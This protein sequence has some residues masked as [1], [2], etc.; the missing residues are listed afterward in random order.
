MNLSQ[1]SLVF[2]FEN[3]ELSREFEKW[4][5]NLQNGKLYFQVT[6]VRDSAAIV[7]STRART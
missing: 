3:T 5:N 4:F 6:N 2:V 7:T 1:F